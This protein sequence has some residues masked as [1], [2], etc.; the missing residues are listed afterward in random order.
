MHIWLIKLEESFPSDEGFRPYRMHMLAEALV[1]RGHQVTR[2]ASDFNHEKLVARE[3][4]SH[5]RQLSPN[6]FVEFMHSSVGYRS[7]VSARR[8]LNN[9]MLASAF[10]RAASRRE[11]PDLILC[12]MPTPALCAQAAKYAEVHNIPLILD[13]RDL[14]PDVIEEALSSRTQRV[15]AK[16]VI[17]KMRHDL[18]YAARQATG[19]V[20]ITSFYREHLLRY[21]GREAGP[22]DEEFP[23]GFS[24]SQA[25][26]RES[27]HPQLQTIEHR[28]IIYFAGRLGKSVYSA[29]D[30]VLEGAQLLGRSAP[31]VTFVLCGEG[32]YGAQMKERASACP[33]IIFPGF[34]SQPEL[35][36]L[37]NRAKLALLPI[38][39]RR[40]YQMS[41]SNKI[42]EYM[43]AGLPIV[44]HLDGLPGELIQREEIGVVYSDAAEL[45][46]L[47]LSCLSDENRRVEMGRRA[48]SL[49]RKKYCSESVY[50]EYACYVEKVGMRR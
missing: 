2:W 38:E 25:E 21:A 4:C 28:P 43:S 12:S 41:L 7:Q 35:A 3:G 6:Y 40:D 29:F 1:N 47:V 49:Y 42:F 11:A 32:D 23:L 13:A 9:E 14:W 34:L 22:F 46:R 17:M 5:R 18:R 8:L 24:S 48:A 39:R 44:S 45:E 27:C 20:G 15:L 50:D 37:R 36:W 26:C 19:L 10:R 31:E 33:N 30:H 16:P